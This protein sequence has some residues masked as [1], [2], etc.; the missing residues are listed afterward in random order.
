MGSLRILKHYSLNQVDI[1]IDYKIAVA[2]TLMMKS[3]V[4]IIVATFINCYSSNVFSCSCI[5][6]TPINKI[7][8]TPIIFSGSVIDVEKLDKKR[9]FSSS[10]NRTTFKVDKVY[11]GVVNE[12]IV[13]EHGTNGISCGFRFK[14]GQ[15]AMFFGS[16]GGDKFSTGLCSMFIPKQRRLVIRGEQVPSQSKEDVH[17]LLSKLFEEKKA[18]K[19]DIRDG[20]INTHIKLIDFL[21]EW[22]DLQQAEYQL[23]KL[24]SLNIGNTKLLLRLADISFRLKK[25]N[26]VISTTEKI[27]NLNEQNIDAYVFR[28]RAILIT[29]G[30]IDETIKDWEGIKSKR[31]FA[32]D[33]EL[34]GFNFSSTNLNGANFK[35]AKLAN[36]SFVDAHLNTVEFNGANLNAADLSNIYGYQVDFTK[37]DLSKAN[38]REATFRRSDFSLTD[39]TA[40]Q[41]IQANFESS[42][43]NK[44][45]LIDANFS[46]AKFV[47]AD[48]RNIDFGN[49]ILNHA[50]FERAKLQGA[51]LVNSSI[52]KT[53]FRGAHVDCETIFPKSF[54]Q[55][56]AVVIPVQARCGSEQQNR[57]FSNLNLKSYDFNKLDL[58]GARFVNSKVANTRFLSA[59]LRSADFSGADEVR[60]ID[61]ADLTN[62]NL[63]NLKKMFHI[64]YTPSP[65]SLKNVIFKGTIIKVGSFYRGDERY[66]PMYEANLDGAIIDCP[67]TDPEWLKKR[68][69]DK[70]RV[71]KDDVFDK[72]EEGNKKAFK[73]IPELQEMWPTLTLTP[74]CEK[75]LADNERG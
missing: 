58:Q 32:E 50:N 18:L 53:E 4:M 15:K 33:M 8:S 47:L 48:L 2:N 24:I 73:V 37:A 49:A 28:A 29:K 63:S 52:K 75:Y 70:R 51:N 35:N 6:F 41:A 61:D 7:K 66:E 16:G 57:D 54:D 9:T 38:L 56:A 40:V 72:Y 26:H 74:R 43:F 14:M 34:S 36:S 31:L 65:R 62:A 42:V 1:L 69:Q 44:T 67:M 5:S 30:V 64:H 11:K 12:I 46:N 17:T 23:N 68:R 39:M 10:F 45:K 19:R 59:D 55:R 60:Y 25:Y 13:A 20:D 71:Y 27:L 22:G 21:E 3:F